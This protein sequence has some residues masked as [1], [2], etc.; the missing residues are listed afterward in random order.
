MRDEDGRLDD[1][2]QPRDLSEYGS[3]RKTADFCI[4]EALDIYGS[5]LAGQSNG[6]SDSL[7][8]GAIVAAFDI[9]DVPALDRPQLAQHML[10]IHHHVR[11]ISNRKANR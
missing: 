5:Y 7:D 8:L 9:E 2:Q 6:M 10:L 1:G 4:L 3:W 11:E